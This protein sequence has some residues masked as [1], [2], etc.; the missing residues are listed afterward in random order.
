MAS[1]GLV[2][3]EKLREAS[4]YGRVALRNFP[5]AERFQL[6]AEIRDCTTNIKRLLL[7]ALHRYH[8]KTTMEDI[9][10]ELNVLRSLVQESHDLHYINM[11]QYEVWSHHID[12]VGAIFGAWYKRILQAANGG[13]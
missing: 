10:I 1:D 7:R 9:D 5:K 12:E 11:H 6:G 13:Q 2:I 4:L 8:K 3:M